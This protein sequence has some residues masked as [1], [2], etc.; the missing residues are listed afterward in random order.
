MLAILDT[1]RELKPGSIIPSIYVLAVTQE[2]GQDQA[3]DVSDI[4]VVR[5]RLT[6]DPIVR[7]IVENLR[8]YHEHAATLAAACAL[9]ESID[10]ILWSKNRR[11]GWV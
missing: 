11:H 4:A 7:L 5:E 2:I 6:G 8:V 1:A 3:N 9:S 10:A